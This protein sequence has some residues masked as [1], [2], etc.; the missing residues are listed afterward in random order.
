[1]ANV[2]GANFQ[3]MYVDEPKVLGASGLQHTK[4]RV[5]ADEIASASA[6]DKCFIGELPDEAFIISAEVVGAATG[7]TLEDGDGNAIA[8]GERVDGRKV[9]VAI[10]DAGVTN[11]LILVKYLQC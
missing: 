8:L 7:V 9:L 5:I 6:S 10:P 1:M 11:G 3:K 4:M 2:N